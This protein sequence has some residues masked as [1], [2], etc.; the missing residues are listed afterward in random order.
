MY[1]TL[2]EDCKDWTLE[3]I[4]IRPDFRDEKIERTVKDIIDNVRSRKDKALIEYA[5]KFD[6]SELENNFYASEEEFEEAERLVSADLK[7]AIEVSYKNIYS[8]HAAQ[9]SN[10]EEV[11]TVKGCKCWRKIVPIEKVGLYIPGG[12]APLFSTILMLAIPAKIAGCRQIILSTPM[13]DNKISPIILYT[14]KRVGI[15]K[16]LKCGGAQ[17]IAAL[18]YGTE[19]VEKVDKIFGPGNRY[20][21]LAKYLV[22]SKTAIDMIAGPSEV[23]VVQDRKAKA[24][25]VAADL[26]SQAEHGLDSQVGLIVKADT[27]EEGRSLLKAV[28]AEIDNFLK[29]L[30]RTDY[31]KA[32]LQNSFA[33]ILTSDED[34][35][36]AVNYYAP[37]HLVINT[38][39]AKALLDGV[40]NAGS[41]F[42]G[43]YSCEA[44]GDYSSGTNHTLPTSGFA[45]SSSGVSLDSFIKKITCQELK[46]EGVEALA[47]S[48][49]LMAEAE[50]LSS[51][52]LAMRVRRDA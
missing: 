28:E 26:L 29:T 52:A 49:I 3:K 8:F 18:S 47:E 2:Y 6:N 40:T 24:E 33:M 17:A 44:C 20:V 36:K 9:I 31:I 27:I 11:E 5:N 38:E 41:V 48:V 25:Y 12:T 16:V 22:S 13:K 45:K 14:A 15:K 50:G 1:F 37:E 32:S 42:V 46:R 43:P 34:V 30:D 23:L 39:N 10:P 19:S 35:I 21:S 4:G 51:H 7:E